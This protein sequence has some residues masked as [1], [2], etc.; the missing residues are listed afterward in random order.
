M[1]CGLKPMPIIEASRCDA[2]RL[3]GRS[4]TTD[5]RHG[6]QPTAAAVVSMK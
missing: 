5:R 1:G 3:L 4:A 6:F 2:G